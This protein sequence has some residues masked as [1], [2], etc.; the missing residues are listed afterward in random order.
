MHFCSLYYG[1]TAMT[2][3]VDDHVEHHEPY[4]VIHL[5]NTYSPISLMLGGKSSSLSANEAQ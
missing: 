3:K 1:T 2:R 4:E 5:M